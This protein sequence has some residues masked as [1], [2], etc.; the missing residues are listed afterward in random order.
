MDSISGAAAAASVKSQQGSN[1][2]KRIRIIVNNASIEGL[3]IDL[4]PVHD[5]YVR[6]RLPN[7][8]SKSKDNSSSSGRHK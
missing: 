2:E 5:E 6:Q 8:F 4:F 7:V 3:V 1:S